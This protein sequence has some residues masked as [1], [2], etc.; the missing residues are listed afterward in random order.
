[1][2]DAF[3]FIIFHLLFS[4]KWDFKEIDIGFANSTTCFLKHEV[5]LDATFSRGRRLSNLFKDLSLLN[6]WEVSG[7]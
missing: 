3:N 6:G 5:E 4:H 7:L 1:M 2:N